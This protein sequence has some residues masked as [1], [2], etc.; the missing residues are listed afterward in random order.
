MDALAAARTKPL[1]RWIHALGIPN[2]GES[3]ADLLARGFSSLESLWEADEFVFA[4]IE[5]IGPEVGRSVRA[6]VSSHPGLPTWLKAHGVRPSLELLPPV[7]TISLEAW[8]TTIGIPELGLVT[9]RKLIERAGDMSILWSMTADEVMEMGLRHKLLNKKQVNIPNQL[10]QFS[11]NHPVIPRQ[12]E[13]LGLKLSGE[14][15]GLQSSLPLEGMTVVVTGT[16]PSLSREDAEGMLAKLGAKVVGS[17]S[18]KTS[19]L[20]AGDKAGSKLEKAISLGVSVKNE[21]WLLG[22]IKGD[23]NV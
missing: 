2:V 22:F 1:S 20:V 12:L 10:A 19:V 8:L 16:L 7:P 11:R 23:S 3:S 14:S 13:Q 6:F 21:D 9:A 15:R 5:S 18:S 4:G 17:V